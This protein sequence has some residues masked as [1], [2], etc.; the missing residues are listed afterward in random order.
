MADRDPGQQRQRPS[1]LSALAAHA[2]AC[3]VA[4]TGCLAGNSG[5]QRRSRDGELANNPGAAGKASRGASE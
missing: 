3:M 4:A 1:E 5:Q 2:T